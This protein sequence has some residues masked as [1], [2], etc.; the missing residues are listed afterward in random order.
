MQS[1]GTRDA[2][3]RDGQRRPGRASRARLAL[4][5][6][7]EGPG[8]NPI[9]ALH[10]VRPGS[11]SRLPV[12]APAVGRPTGRIHSCDQERPSQPRLPQPGQDPSRRMAEARDL[13]HRRRDQGRA[14]S[15][16]RGLRQDALLL[17]PQP[18]LH[19][20]LHGRGDGRGHKSARSD[21]HAG[22]RVHARGVGSRNAAGE[23]WGVGQRGGSGGA[24]RVRGS[25]RGERVYGRATT[26]SAFPAQTAPARS[27]STQPRLAR[28]LRPMALQAED[29]AGNLGGVLPGNRPRRQHCAGRRARSRSREATHGA[30]A[31]TSTSAWINP[32]EGDRAPITASHYRLCAIGRRRLHHGSP[33][34]EVDTPRRS[35]GAEPRRVGNCASGVRTRRETM[36]RPMLQFR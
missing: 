7:D 5:L 9:R 36:N 29:A 34:G 27:P 18:Q 17:R 6:R 32:D 3:A 14:T 26:P 35:L 2:R 4:V 22:Q 30:T 12:R 24:A 33:V 13:R 16:L 1:G 19:P 31:T 15:P 25:S 28:E 11:S 21:D 10:L 23:L 8:G 20:H